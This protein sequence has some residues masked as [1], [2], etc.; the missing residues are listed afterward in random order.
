MDTAALY[1]ILR[2]EGIGLDIDSQ[3]DAIKPWTMALL[4]S[5]EDFEDTFHDYLAEMDQKDFWKM[6]EKIIRARQELDHGIEHTRSTRP[7]FSEKLSMLY[8]DVAGD[9]LQDIGYMVLETIYQQTEKTV[10]DNLHDWFMDCIG[11]EA[12]M[13]EGM[14]EDAQ[15]AREDR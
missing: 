9:K 3:Q 6:Q 2:E 4:A 8:F 12:D 10:T 7:G 14:R 15:E 11:Y 1:N 13:E 5:K